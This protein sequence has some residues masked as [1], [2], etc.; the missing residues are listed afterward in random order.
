MNFI[1]YLHLRSQVH[2]SLVHHLESSMQ[3]HCYKQILGNVLLPKKKLLPIQRRKA[4]W[5]NK[6]NPV[7]GD[8]MTSASA[9]IFMWNCNCRF[10]IIINNHVSP[11]K[12]TKI[13]IRGQMLWPNV[14]VKYT[15]TYIYIYIYFKLNV[16]VLSLSVRKFY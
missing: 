13:L 11:H 7:V 8:T 1:L 5:E 6:T 16:I 14:M 15:H 10:L 4:L 3:S 9:N 2:Q 12:P